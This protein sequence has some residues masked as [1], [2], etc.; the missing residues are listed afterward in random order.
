MKQLAREELHER[1][2]RRAINHGYRLLWY[3]QL[4][5]NTAG[6]L[7]LSLGIAGVVLHSAVVAACG[8][9]IAIGLGF[10]GVSIRLDVID[11]LPR[12]SHD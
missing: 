7:G 10:V 1:V 9:A 2:M 12:S 6:G 5:V 8:A 3:S 11:R 4:F